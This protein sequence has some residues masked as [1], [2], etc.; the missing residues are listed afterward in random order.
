[1]AV[2]KMGFEES[3]GLIRTVAA[4]MDSFDV[5]MM[6]NDVKRVIALFA[7]QEALDDDSII[8]QV[9]GEY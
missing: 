4:L 8:R 7:G 2:I 6:P 1:M 9:R 5:C 3:N